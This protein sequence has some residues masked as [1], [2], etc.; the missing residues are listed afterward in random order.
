MADLLDR[1]RSE[2]RQRLDESRA[3]VREYE[4]LESALAA[5]DGDGEPVSAGAQTSRRSRRRKR[6]DPAHGAARPRARRGA[7]REAVLR[8]VG[9]RPGVA[10]AELAAASGVDRKVLYGLLRRL[11]ERGELRKEA[12]PAGGT[13]YALPRANDVHNDRRSDEEP[14][15]AAS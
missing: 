11:T 15:P 10:V 8:V 7:N 13:G 3:A 4:R 5:L 12:L 9:E 6:A 14:P 2:I 1:I